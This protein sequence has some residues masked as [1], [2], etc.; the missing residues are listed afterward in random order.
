MVASFF[1]GACPN[2]FIWAGLWAEVLIAAVIR[3]YAVPTLHFGA[4]S[5]RQPFGRTAR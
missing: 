3:L 4:A 2:K 1:I 5:I